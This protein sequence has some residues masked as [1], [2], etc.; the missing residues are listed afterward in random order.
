MMYNEVLV[1]GFHFIDAT[2]F[3]ITVLFKFVLNKWLDNLL[4]SSSINKQL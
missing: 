2:L 1:M 4:R 3:H